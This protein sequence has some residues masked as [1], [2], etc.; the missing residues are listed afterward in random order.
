VLG[1][2]D[3]RPQRSRPLGLRRLA[4]RERISLAE[5]TKHR[6]FGDPSLQRHHSHP[7]LPVFQKNQRC[8]FSG[9][10]RRNTA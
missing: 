7:A 6:P 3:A 9:W 1:V 4:Q 5:L 2:V 8:G 10:A